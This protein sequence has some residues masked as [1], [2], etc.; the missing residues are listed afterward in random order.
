MGGE[1]GVVRTKMSSNKPIQ[2]QSGITE[3]IS[4]YKP[5]VAVI[6]DIN[7][8]KQNLSAN[9]HASGAKQKGETHISAA[10]MCVKRMAAAARV[11]AVQSLVRAP[12]QHGLVIVSGVIITHHNRLSFLHSFTR[13]HSP[14]LSNTCSTT[15]GVW[16]GVCRA[17][18][19]IVQ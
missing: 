11:I 7:S 13:V 18:A 10:C 9:A 8:H 3:H 15:T 1:D 12:Q 16:P 17:L 4:L 5:S 6:N 2:T 19:F 14:S